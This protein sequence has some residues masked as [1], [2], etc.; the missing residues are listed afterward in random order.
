M[1][2]HGLTE[3]LTV[4]AVKVKRLLPTNEFKSRHVTSGKVFRYQGLWPMSLMFTGSSRWESHLANPSL[5]TP[6]SR[7][8]VLPNAGKAKIH[9]Y[10]EEPPSIPPFSQPARKTQAQIRGNP[11]RKQHARLSED[12]QK[13]M[14][15]MCDEIMLRA[16]RCRVQMPR[17]EDDERIPPVNRLLDRP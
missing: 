12:Y 1:Y 10:R 7:P 11:C 4:L 13:V 15:R 9:V 2:A 14:P 16:C 3:P 8:G 6:T 17:D 5:Q